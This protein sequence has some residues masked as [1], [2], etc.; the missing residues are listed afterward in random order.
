MHHRALVLI[1]VLLFPVNAIFL[2]ILVRNCTLSCCSFFWW[3]SHWRSSNSSIRN[4]RLLFTSWVHRSMMIIVLLL[5]VATWGCVLGL[6]L[7][8]SSCWSSNFYLLVSCSSSD[9]GRCLFLLLGW[10]CCFVQPW[11]DAFVLRHNR[12]RGRLSLRVLTLLFTTLILFAAM[13][14]ACRT[15]FLMGRLQLLVFLLL[16]GWKRGSSNLIQHFSSGS[17]ILGILLDYLHEKDIVA[18][19]LV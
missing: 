1:L 6:R 17:I 8:S 13:G 16:L 11:H 14:A 5:M 10:I 9:W 12:P 19:G 15:C 18:I 3:G 2:L 4:L 7:G